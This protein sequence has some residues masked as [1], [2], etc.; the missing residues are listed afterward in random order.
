MLN[1]ITRGARAAHVYDQLRE[2]IVRG[3][4]APGARVVEQEVAA[5][6][7]VGRT[8]VRE[9]LQV[10]VQEHLLVASAGGRRLLSVAP[11]RADDAAELFGLVAE[12]EACA[13]RR[14]PSL[15]AAARAELAAAAR[16]ANAVFGA[17][18]GRVPLDQE[19]AFVTHKAFHA[20]LTAPLAGERL[21]WLLALVRPQVDRYEWFCG[22]AL[23]GELDVATREHEVIVR[24][25]EEGDAAAA[26]AA[27]RTNW[28]NAS[29][30][31]APAIHRH[32]ASRSR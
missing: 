8:P 18:V 15:D 6:L 13:L 14:L 22:A 28:R 19:A 26:E 1:S 7:G 25:L 21:A 5:Q 10:L 3:V 4:L 29:Q 16:A 31:L 30:R 17:A 24:A 32:E 9:A 23:E 27:L 12:L 2:R 11:L 20:T